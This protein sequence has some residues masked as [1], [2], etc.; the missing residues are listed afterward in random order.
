MAI[1]MKR[2]MCWLVILGL[3]VALRLVLFVR[4]EETSSHLPHSVAPAEAS[5]Q[6]ENIF[7]NDANPW[8]Q[9]AAKAEVAALK[10]QQYDVASGI[11]Q[12][13]IASGKLTQQEDRAVRNAILGLNEALVRAKA[14]GDA[15]AA[16]MLNRLEKH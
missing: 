1:L 9:E 10:N 15:K 5:V 2:I 4:H 16:E 11:L 3:V 13:M 14:A 7:A 8:A 12:E 6:I